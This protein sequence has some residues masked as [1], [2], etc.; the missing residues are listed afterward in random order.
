MPEMSIELPAVRAGDLVR[1]GQCS[2]QCLV[3][4]GQDPNECECT[5]AGA[6]HGVLANAEVSTDRDV[7]PWWVQ[8]D[9]CGWSDAALREVVPEVRAVKSGNEVWQRCQAAGMPYT[10][11]R[12]SGRSWVFELDLAPLGF[13][14]E[15]IEELWAQR[16]ANIVDRLLHQL[17]ST[18]RMTSATLPPAS[19]VHGSGIQ[20]EL[21]ARLIAA[22]VNDGFLGHDSTIR[23]ALTILDNDAGC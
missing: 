14:D 1:A 5:C 9:N 8:C 4:A 11:I 16:H 12:R 23:R 6:F 15:K 22:L 17:L 10:V 19:Y 13:S 7:R 2:P 3:A 20:D 21:E 18:G